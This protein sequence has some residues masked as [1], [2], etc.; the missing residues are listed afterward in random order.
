[1]HENI[2]S[3]VIENFEKSIKKKKIKTLCFSGGGIKGF[4]FIGALENLIERKIIDLKKIKSF[5]GTSIGA[6]L[7]FLL[8]LGWNIEEIKNFIF[9]FNFIKLQSEINSIAFLEKF[10][11]QEGKRIKL[12]FI[13]FLESKLNVSD[14]T[15][16]E[17]FKSTN[18]KLTIIGTNLSKSQEVIFNYKNTP[19]FSVI[20]ALRISISVPIIFTPVKH[21]DEYYID[22]GVVNNFPINHCS[23]NSTIGF[24]I[25]NSN[26]NVIT[27]IKD[28]I[29]S[30]I[31][32]TADT[33]NSKNIKKYKKNIIEIKYHE[34]IYTKFDID[35]EQILKLIKVGYDA[36][37]NFTNFF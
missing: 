27:S 24:Y 37:N 23:K 18:K 7:S 15:F 25:K 31:S 5:V 10:G 1:M 20:S 21:E 22:G 9:N 33:I 36:A 30:V 35:K 13:K 14:I 6:I 26:M 29:T 34:F 2:S 28:I 32:I 4:S 19:N 11:I 8:N 3:I 17:L 12:L 16:E